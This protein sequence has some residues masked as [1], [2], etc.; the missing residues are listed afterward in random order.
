[1]DS[2]EKL[3][4]GACACGWYGAV[5]SFGQHV[6]Q[7]VRHSTLDEMSERFRHAIAY[8]GSYRR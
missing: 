3:E 2:H 7:R 6:G 5:R 8:V 4:H 1:M